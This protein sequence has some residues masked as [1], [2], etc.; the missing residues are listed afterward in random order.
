MIYIIDDTPRTQIEKFF[1]PEDYADILKLYEDIAPEEIESL[2]DG[3]C[4]LIHSSFHNQGIKKKVSGSICDYG[5]LIPLVLFSDGDR[6]EAVFDGDRYITEYNK[7][8][9]YSHLPVF[10]SYYRKTGKS[11]LNVLALGE[12]AIK[13]SLEGSI[14]GK[15]YILG[16][17]DALKDALG[18]IHI[19]FPEGKV[20]KEK[21]VHDFMT[22]SFTEPASLI[23]M[24]LDGNPAFCMDLAMHIR[25]SQNQLGDSSRCPI[26]LVSE[27]PM[28]E[29]TGYS[30]S[31]IFL[32]ES[33][34][35]CPEEKLGAMM[36]KVRPLSQEAYRSAFLDR[37]SVRRPEGSNHSL[38]N[39]WGASR[40]YRIV[41]GHEISPEEYRGFNDIQKELYYKFIMARITRTSE[42]PKYA[43]NEKVQ[44]S[45]GKKILLIDDEADKGWARTI[46]KI[47]PTSGFNPESDVICE[48][49]SDYESLSLE[50]RNKIENGGYDLFLLDLRLN[51]DVENSQ[52][53]PQKMSGYKVLHRIK[54]FNRGN[55]VIMLTASNKAW[56]LKALL[57][58]LECASGYF[59]K[60]SPEYEFSD[61]FSIANLESFRHDAELCF[62]RGYLKRFWELL[63]KVRT[64]SS[65]DGQTGRKKAFLSELYSQMQIAFGLCAQAAS[66]QAFK[67][68]YLST[69]QNFE[70]IAS[71]Y[72]FEV[73]NATAKQKDLWIRDD[74]DKEI[75][76]LEITR[77]A[78]RFFYRTC[79]GNYFQTTKQHKVFSQRDKLT[80]LFLQKWGQ[81][82]DGFISLLEQLIICR[83]D[84]I[85]KNDNDRLR[86][87][88]KLDF[89]RIFSYPDVND[90]HLF[91]SRR[92]I[93]ETLEAVSMNGHLYDNGH[94]MLHSDIVNNE[95]GVTLLLESLTR[96]IQLI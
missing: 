32:T 17:S 25:L 60:E 42:G 83:N 67:Y 56:N 76:C 4:I 80:A 95:T 79:P 23:I 16:G 22:T 53:E 43:Y 7:S 85:H 44:N 15:R 71:H 59:I 45:H 47:F 28:D 24:N 35:L 72:I 69:F 68:A 66:P 2:R 18:G 8:K 73:Y 75:Q 61:E 3:C 54:S 88:R 13:E 58:P 84:L 38:A 26:V 52:T 57:D 14:S 40:L 48:Q 34:Y 51:S 77:D 89:T 6:S 50:A 10:L 5:D 46:E 70:V 62:S 31:Q 49:V 29:L 36:E 82:D 78:Q 20:S 12:S 33:I 90:T 19:A 87:A 41:S 39:Q 96:L 92:H 1:S 9:M 81:T 63:E 74:D 93:R 30:Q 94:I 27:K 86:D 11:D 55:Q 91:F 65:Q 37:I 21:D 64:L